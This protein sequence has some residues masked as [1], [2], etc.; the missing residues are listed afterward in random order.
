[1]PCVA[2]RARRASSACKNRTKPND[3][4]NL[5]HSSS[6]PKVEYITQRSSW[7]IRRTRLPINNFRSA[8][9][10]TFSLKFELWTRIEKCTGEENNEINRY[11]ETRLV[12]WSSAPPPK[13][14][15][16]KNWF[17]FNSRHTISSFLSFVLTE[18]TYCPSDTKGNFQTRRISRWSRPSMTM[19]TIYPFRTSVPDRIDLIDETRPW[20]KIVHST[21]LLLVKDV[22]RRLSSISFLDW[23]EE[24]EIQQ[25]GS[26]NKERPGVRQ[27][28]NIKR[29]NKRKGKNPIGSIRKGSH[30]R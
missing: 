16:W 25:I 5:A 23:R 12:S 18:S 30:G 27:E 24:R 6:G 10:F 3:S 11:G 20:W 4:W 21:S 7:V 2:S 19:I 28:K 15:D 8:I 26:I 9:D 14:I 13:R 17:E 1:M 22:G 29:I